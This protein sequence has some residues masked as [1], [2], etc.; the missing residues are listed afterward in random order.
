MTQ[1]T[2]CFAAVLLLT[3]TG[4]SLVA[5]TPL[6]APPP[7]ST[8]VAAPAAI[9]SFA[10]LTLGGY[11]VLRLRAAAG[12]MTAQERIDR[13]TERLTPLLGIPDIRPSDIVVFL[14]PVDSHINRSPVIYALGRKLI[15]VD[16]ATVAAAGGGGTPLMMASKWAARLQQVLPR[17]NWR[18]AN[19]PETKVPPHPPLTVTRNFAQVGGMLGVVRLRGKIVLKLRGP[20]P[21]GVTAA[22]R[23]D[24]LPTRLDQLASKTGAELPDAVQVAALPDGTATLTVSGTPFVTVTAPDAVA[25][26]FKAPLPL[27]QGWAKNLRAA[28]VQ[29]PP[30][31]LLP[32]P[33]TQVPGDTPTPV[34]APAAPITVPDTVLPAPTP[35]PTTPVPTTPVPTLPVAPTSPAPAPPV[36]APTPPATAPPVAPTPDAAPVAPAK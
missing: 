16:T 31:P 26:G 33:P 23:A 6:V 29:P 18:P 24:L 21:G 34:P 9:S 1:N 11:P 5:Q 27:A 19:R 25:A 36:I 32:V 20:Q 13:I 17:V 22:E 3:L 15:T 35:E 8:P 12:G 2:T 30:A 10:D 7:A 14:P 4:G 28:L